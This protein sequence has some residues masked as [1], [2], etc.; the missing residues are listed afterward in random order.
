MYKKRAKKSGLRKYFSPEY[1]TAAICYLAGSGAGKKS[2][3]KTFH[4]KQ[5]VLE[6]C[7]H[8]LGQQRIT[9]QSNVAPIFVLQPRISAPRGSRLV[10]NG[11][12][13][14]WGQ[15]RGQQCWAGGTEGLA[16]PADGC[17]GQMHRQ[18]RGW[19]HGYR[20]RWY[21]G[22]LIQW[23]KYKELGFE[24]VP[25]EQ[26]GAQDH[27]RDVGAAVGKSVPRRALRL[28]RMWTIKS[29][30]K[31]ASVPAATATYLPTVL[32]EALLV[33]WTGCGDTAS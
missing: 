9:E 12:N 17:T 27:R 16:P 11:C 29:T 7:L 15:R 14:S 32:S 31:A 22:S 19:G 13:Q 18:G 33:N 30:T 26:S 21:V 25:H 8:G 6:G 28:T 23:Q 5:G 4:W 20:H 1:F 10:P 3:W 24:E 2:A